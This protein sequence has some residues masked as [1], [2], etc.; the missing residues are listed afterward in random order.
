MW[1]TTDHRFNS[2]KVSRGGPSDAPI[3]VADVSGRGPR[4]CPSRRRPSMMDITSVLYF[5][6][7]RYDVRNPLWEQRD[8]FIL[9]K[10]HGALAYYEALCLAGF[11]DRKSVV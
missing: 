8:R 7:L 5:G 1:E 2:R 3:C 9:S 10:G 11:I 6:V 4:R